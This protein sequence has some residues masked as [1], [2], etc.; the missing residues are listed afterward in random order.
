VQL[1]EEPLAPGECIRCGGGSSPDARFC[2]HCGTPL[3]IAD[4]IDR[5]TG[6]EVSWFDEAASDRPAAPIVTAAVCEL[7]AEPA[8]DGE[9]PW[10]DGGPAEV[11]SST[12]EEVRAALGR[13]GAV[14]EDLP[15]EMATLAA[16]F[17]P[18]PADGDGPTR[19]ARAAAE[20]R[21]ILTERRA[22]M[23]AGIGTADIVGDGPGAGD[24]WRQRVIDLA[25]RLQRMAE[26]GDI[27]VAEGAYRRV[28]G[29]VELQPLAHRVR[30][31]GEAPSGPLRL[32][33]VGPDPATVSLG[34]PPLVG[35]E[36]E[37]A[38]IRSA[39]DRAVSEERA[40]LVRIEGAAGVGASHL[41]RTSLDEL[42][43]E[44]RAATAVIRCSPA[45]ELGG[46]EA[47]ARLLE[48][49]ADVTPTAP[50]D[51]V[52]QV[53]RDVLPDDPDAPTAAARLGPV[54]GL[55]GE[56]DP[57]ETAWALGRLF[58]AAS[59]ERSL[60]ILLDDAD[61][62]G[63]W[64]LDLVAAS[65]SDADGPVL[66]VATGSE[67]AWSPRWDPAA[68][69]R[70]RLEALDREAMGS[71]AASLL[72]DPEPDPDVL[73]PL[74]DA[75]GGNALHLEQLAAAMVDRGELRF[76]HRRWVV[77]DVTPGG[78]LD[79]P[80]PAALVAARLDDLD[81]AD[82]HAIGLLAAAGDGAPR[83]L[84]S[85]LGAEG[86][87]HAIDERLTSLATR[88]LLRIDG[89][90]DE[91]FAFAHDVV[92]AAVP[93][94]PPEALVEA[95]ERCARWL[96]ERDGDRLP[97]HAPTIAVHLETAARLGRET[98]RTGGDPAR[99]A[100]GLLASSA[101]LRSA[102]GDRSGAV[103]DLRRAGDL[104][105]TDDPTRAEILLRTAV[106][107]I[108]D[109]RDAEAEPVL[110]QAARAAREA[111]DAALEARAR[112][113][114]A[115]LPAGARGRDGVEAIW[116]AAGQ[117]ETVC[118]EAA[119]EVGLAA[120][121]SAR[122]L[123]HRRWGHWAAAA[124][125]AE[126]AADHAERAGRQREA[127]GY[128]LTLALA[129]EDGSAPLAEAIE[130]GRTVL[131]RAGGRRRLVREVAGVLALLLARAG[132]HD[133]AAEQMTQAREAAEASG[134]PSTLGRVLHRAARVEAL[135][136]RTERAEELLWQALD[137]AVGGG[138]DGLRAAVASTLAHMMVDL[139]RG[140]E[141]L[142]L[143]DE[144]S[145]TA[146]G[147]DVL[148]QVG[149]RSARARALAASGR[150]WEAGTLARDAVR[151][152][153]QT[154]LMDLRAGALLSVAEVL[155]AEGRPDE[156]APF[157]RRALR[158]LER[159]GAVVPAERARGMLASLGRPTA[160]VAPAP[161]PADDASLEQAE[162]PDGEPGASE[163]AAEAPREDAGQTGE[164]RWWSFS[165][166]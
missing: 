166:S 156:A 148:T 132:S 29:A 119:D 24:L 106:A 23:R 163:D 147:D 96:E 150:T 39:F 114:K 82:R 129:L 89:A 30:T 135:A 162:T 155:R 131:A 102:V 93:A 142:P 149:W 160:P 53:L 140:E 161:P 74:L 59:S 17:G 84:L 124:D 138:D 51:R 57:E 37:R 69:E 10:N 125:D 91:T 64:F 16:V 141:A 137:A 151:L 44:G 116:E 126:R 79:E 5:E 99:R 87:T 31:D 121:W 6:D 28:G 85:A 47:L 112:L 3:G 103:A 97:R 152:A 4:P 153:E 12:V 9:S 50:A 62:A 13:A 72:L 19:A 34:R 49:I 22:T 144:A 115:V 143:L 158:A 20:V 159:R 76:E 58:R 157:A 118:V 113:R 32:L 164:G 90:G 54:L 95:H 78:P 123:V 40:V 98:G 36:A 94:I 7:S 107:L 45:A 108:A 41:A 61:R 56:A 130:R 146:D 65:A 109:G 1:P 92:R 27:V 117:V 73:G 139:D 154:D 68:V 66:V 101:E 127:A 25:T 165:R 100:A 136:G 70:I 2:Q 67:G 48:V 134:S 122:A 75:C 104:L 128:L 55:D 83:A 21:E 133:E 63:T 77:G 71:L 14:V 86:D 11:P 111:G 35:R 43:D 110:S 42:A 88:R 105:E 26:V 81:P 52:R 145:R 18:E 8:D 46:T 15:G 120:A 80:D 38:R 33:E 60:A